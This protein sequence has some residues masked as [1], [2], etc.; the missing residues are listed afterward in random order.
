MGNNPACCKF[1]VNVKEACGYV[2]P[3]QFCNKFTC[4]C[5][6]YLGNSCGGCTCSNMAWSDPVGDLPDDYVPTPD[7]GGLIGDFTGSIDDVDTELEV[8]DRAE[9]DLSGSLLKP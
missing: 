6:N 4:S 8:V 9:L 2:P 1:A 7:Q 3:G 5:Q